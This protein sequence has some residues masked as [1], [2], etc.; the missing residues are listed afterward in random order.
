MSQ[1]RLIYAASESN[2]D[3]FYATR[4][5]AP[6]PFIFFEIRGQ[7]GIVL[8]DLEYSRGRKIARVDEILSLSELQ[9]KVQKRTGRRKLEVVHVICELFRERKVRRVLV[10]ADFP[11]LLAT[12]L[13]ASGIRVA[14]SKGSFWPE[15]S[16]KSPKEVAMIDRAVQLAE[17]GI[18]RGIDVLRRS[19]SSKCGNLIWSGTP[20]T[21]ER[22]RAEI[23]TAVLH[24]GGRSE[25]TIV[26][27]GIQACDPH[28]RGHGPLKQGEL[29]I[30][31]VF[32]RDMNSGY[33][34]DL[35]RTVVRGRASEAQRKLWTAVR[36][37]QQA[38]LKRVKPGV[39]GARLQ[40]DVREAFRRLGYPTE[41][42]NDVMV[43]FF[44]GLGH[45]LGLEIHEPPRLIQTSFAIGNV[46]T[47]EPGLYY[48][49][50]GGVRIEDDIVVTRSGSR[51]LGKRL[52]VELEV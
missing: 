38:V 39:P 24:A 45:G 15:R 51:L 30:L 14:P 35:T 10:P 33:F 46:F 12:Q 4:F 32:P 29:I 13:A 19:T 49:E 31:D 50:V 23:D 44:H 22:L 6:D 17:I 34:G 3:A 26:A 20:L 43:G 48:P 42:R 1:A 27:G 28:E 47:I 52:A 9:A 36:D 25:G 40:K 11:H 41:R 2:A 16:V 7:R 18:N 37:E 8:S 5:P 21:S